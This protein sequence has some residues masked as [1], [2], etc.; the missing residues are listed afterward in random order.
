MNIIIYT[1]DKDTCQTVIIR[2]R[3]ALRPT[4]S[5]T[6]QSRQDRIQL[7][8]SKY[9]KVPHFRN[10]IYWGT[11]RASYPFVRVST[12]SLEVSSCKHERSED[13]ATCEWI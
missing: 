8:I 4:D 1:L 9:N 6:A 13:S 5:R 7:I 12:S 10:F 11:L 3:Q 2:R